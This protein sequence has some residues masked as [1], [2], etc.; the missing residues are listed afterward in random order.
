M[1]KDLAIVI[2]NWNG[3]NHLKTFL[4]SVIKNSTAHRVVLAD[5]AS[6][7]ESI[8]YVTTHFPTVEIVENQENG[9]FA[10]G[11][12]DALKKIDATYYCLL[13]SDVEVTP[14]WTNHPLKLLQSDANIAVCQP[15]IMDYTNRNYF[16]YAGAGGGFIDKLGYPFC[17]GRIFNTL[18]V[19]KNQYDDTVEIFWAT[20]ACMFIKADCFHKIGGFD[21]SYFAHM[22][23]IDLCWRLKNENYKIFY[24]GQSTVYHLGGGTLSS[25]SPKKT[26]LNFRNSLLTLYKN[27]HVSTVKRKVF[28]RMCLDAIA[29]LKFV[30]EGTPSHAIAILKAHQS[31][32]Q[33]KRNIPHMGQNNI[34]THDQIFQ[35]S[36]IKEYFIKKIHYYSDL[37]NGK[38]AA[39]K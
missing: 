24:T 20:G 14:G 9:G 11:Y 27:E 39:V 4:P 16:E 29:F 25:L 6:T 34:K 37:K 18:E 7:D 31:F 28:W 19:D 30:L 17:R 2:L 26:F 22:E 23:E 10:K 1:S 8:E 15:K 5:N 33:L 38:S 13:N 35:L 12:N 3:I 32:Y 36:I 21:A